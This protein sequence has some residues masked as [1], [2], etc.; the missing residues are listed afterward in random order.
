MKIRLGL[1]SNLSSSSGWQASGPRRPWAARGET[2]ARPLLQDWPSHH[3]NPSPSCAAHASP[4]CWPWSP[5]CLKGAI[6]RSA[7]LVAKYCRFHYGISEEMRYWLRQDKGRLFKY[8]LFFAVNKEEL[9][10]YFFLTKA[11][12]KFLKKTP[13]WLKNLIY[14]HN[15]SPSSGSL[16]VAVPVF[17]SLTGCLA[18]FLDFFN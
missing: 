3:W 17:V 1:R 8:K 16:P 6:K 7:E 9:T 14:A 5:T 12:F 15:I 10:T 18:F 13:L 2:H 11:T 4:C